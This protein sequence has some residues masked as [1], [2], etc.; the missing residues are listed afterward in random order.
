MVVYLVSYGW[1]LAISGTSDSN[2]NNMAKTGEP[3]VH[4][5]TIFKEGIGLDIHIALSVY[6]VA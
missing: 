2:I 6:T 5:Q 3:L 4:T 1:Y